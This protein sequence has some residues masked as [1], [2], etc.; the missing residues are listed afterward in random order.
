[1]GGGMDTRNWKHVT[2]DLRTGLRLDS[3]NVRLET[4]NAKVEADIMED[5]F[6][7]E[8]A[9][10]LVEGICAI[11]YLTHETPIVVKRE[12]V[13]VVVEGNRR[14]A[15]L[16]TIQNPLLVP[17][18][19][20]RVSALLKRYPDYPRVSAV[21]VLVAPNQEDA[22]ELIAAIH[23]GNLRRAWTPTRQAAFFQ[24]Q[25]DAG[26]KFED[27]VKRYPTSDVR[28]FVFRAHVVNRF[29]SARYSSPELQDFVASSR[30][31]KGLSTLTR[32]YEAKEFRAL[33][34]LKM[35]DDGTFSMAVSE[36][37]FDAIAGVIVRDMNVGSLNTRTLN[38]VRD[39][40]R[41]TQLMNDVGAAAGISRGSAATGS[42]PAHP[43]PLD[44]RPAREG[45]Q[46]GLAGV[47]SRAL[48]ARRARRDAAGCGAAESV[49]A[50]R[51][52]AGAL[53]RE[54]WSDSN[55]TG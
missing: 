17:D 30:F 24:A 13:D 28:R 21:D 33:T 47:R 54:R 48:P 46:A 16:K 9:L 32:V 36:A 3:K 18:F 50:R 7:N 37:Q 26:R 14:I 35:E 38:K 1:M 55:P 15:A 42:L 44:P 39:N 53:E 2:L 40:S 27:L 10:G 49:H 45:P 41:F 31:K 25:I 5:L 6:A 20:N 4:A 8:D 43:D 29:K 23:T 12:G 34:G 19:S 22:N 51:V 52:G 11:G